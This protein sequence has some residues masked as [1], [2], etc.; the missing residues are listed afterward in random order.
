M[1]LLS[2]RDNQC[3]SKIYYDPA[4]PAGFGS[5]K[6]IYDAVKKKISKK[7]ISNWLLYQETYTRFKPKY[8]NFRRNHYLVD[9]IDDVWESDLIVLNDDVMKNAND[10][11]A[12]IL[13]KLYT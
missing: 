8:K 13:G 11:Y 6:K 10:G 4:H 12:Y 9:N 2:T 3:L 5:V 1:N 7:T